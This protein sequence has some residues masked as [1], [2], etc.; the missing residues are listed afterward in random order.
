M[1]ILF[2]SIDEIKQIIKCESLTALYTLTNKR[3]IISYLNIYFGF[4]ESWL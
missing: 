3:I 4:C 2:V 1:L